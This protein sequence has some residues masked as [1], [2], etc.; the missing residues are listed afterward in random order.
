MKLDS[1]GVGAR[2]THGRITPHVGLGIL[3]Q[4][5][6]EDDGHE[7]ENANLR[8]AETAV[9]SFLEWYRGNVQPA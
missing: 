9:Q 5:L 1:L 4:E 8:H 7:V 6:Q 3:D 2:N